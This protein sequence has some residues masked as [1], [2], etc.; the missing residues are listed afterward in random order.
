MGETWQSRV[1]SPKKPQV[2]GFIAAASMKREGDRDA[3]L[4]EGLAHH[5]EDVALKLGKLVEEGDAVVSQRNVAGPRDGAAADESGVA[6]RVMRRAV[7][8]SADQA[9]GIF[10]NSRDAVYAGGFDDLVERHRRKNHGDAFGD[11]GLPCS[12][13]TDVAEIDRR[14]RPRKTGRGLSLS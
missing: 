12:G 2:H 4:F 6:D 14:R 1:A 13:R 11:P 9:A 10:E 8:A 7:G 3:A 5:F